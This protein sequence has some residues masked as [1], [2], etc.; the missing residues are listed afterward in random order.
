V[1][2]LWAKGDEPKPTK[3][4][5]PTWTY[6]RSVLT[7]VTLL[8]LG[9]VA[10]LT[11]GSQLQNN[12]DQQV[13]YNQFR[14]QLANAVAPVSAL[15]I[16]GNA[17]QSGAPVA[18][19]KIPALGINAVVVEGTTSSDTML[20]PG[21]RR[22]TVLPGQG[23][24]SVIMGRQAAFGGAFGQIST[25]SKGTRFTTTTGQ[26]IAT[27]VVSGVRYANDPAPPALQQGQGRLTLITGE[28]T[29]YLPDSVVRVDAMLDTTSFDGTDPQ[30]VAF[31]TG[32]RIITAAALPESERPMGNDTSQVFFLV[33]WA[34]LFLIAV[35]AFTWA[36]ERWGKW[37]A[38]TVGVPILLAIGWAV[39][40][41]IAVL[42]PN[43]I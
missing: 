30:K 28:G 5:T 37:Q 22:D 2:Q 3:T 16:D 35:V 1:P 6:V 27:Y 32:P 38:W 20:G 36:R 29:K 14:E 18:L 21:H 31:D 11:L 33:L 40:N 8:A 26:G 10:L 12:R 23:G 24:I 25:L 4:L 42:L 9:F 17:V 39:S 13:L 7:G 41:Q 43:L 19:L 15:D 34:Q